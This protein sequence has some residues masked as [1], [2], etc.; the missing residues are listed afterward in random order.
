V[1]SVIRAV[2]ALAA[3]VT[4]VLLWQAAATAATAIE[5]AVL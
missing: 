3:T 4:A 5:Y 1:R 2:V